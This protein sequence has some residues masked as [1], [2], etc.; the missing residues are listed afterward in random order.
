MNGWT[1][2]TKVGFGVNVRQSG[3]CRLQMEK[4]GDLVG[5]IVN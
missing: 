3:A 1:A 4:K 2:R 5:N